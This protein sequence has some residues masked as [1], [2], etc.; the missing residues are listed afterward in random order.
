MWHYLLVIALLPCIGVTV[1]VSGTFKTDILEL[2]P[3]YADPDGPYALHHEKLERN[4]RRFIRFAGPPERFA[5]AVAKAL[6]EHRPFAR[7]GVGID[8]KLLLLGARL[9]PG[10]AL[11]A[12]VGRALGLPRPGSLN[13]GGPRRGASSRGGAPAPPAG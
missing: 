1:L 12:I 4:G 7:H 10:A 2:T 11:Q 3:T 5:E 9:L 8:A 6:D 13:D